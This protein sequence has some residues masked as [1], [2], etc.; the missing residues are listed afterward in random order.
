LRRCNDE[1]NEKGKALDKN[2]GK[3]Y[4]KERYMVILAKMMVEA[5]EAD[6]ADDKGGQMVENNGGMRARLRRLGR[7]TLLLHILST[8]SPSAC[9]MSSKSLSSK[10]RWRE[11]KAR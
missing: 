1:K 10:S 2:Q 9:L 8:S 4:E 6:E 5:D 3:T 7:L 11:A